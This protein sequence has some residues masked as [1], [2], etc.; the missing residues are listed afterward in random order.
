MLGATG[1][2]PSSTDPTVPRLGSG[3][4]PGVRRKV[5]VIVWS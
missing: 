2:A 5:W 3:P 1:A 4:H